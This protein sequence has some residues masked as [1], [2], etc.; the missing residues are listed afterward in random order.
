MEGNFGGGKLLQIWKFATNL[1]K[2][3]PPNTQISIFITKH[4]VKVYVAKFSYS[5]LPKF[6]SIQ[7][8]A[9]CYYTSSLLEIVP[10]L[11]LTT[12]DYLFSF[13]L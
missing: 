5:S 10:N 1:P 7:Y 8:T 3:N 4:F 13:S 11:M 2:F 6:P 12:V 9:T